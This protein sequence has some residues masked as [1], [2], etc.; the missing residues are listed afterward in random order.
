MT[1]D[2]KKLEARKADFV[3]RLHG[4]AK[5]SSKGG[6]VIPK[7]IRDALDIEPG[8]EVSFMLV[9]PTQN[10]KQDKRLSS[11]RI[12][13]VPRTTK[14]VLEI[15]AGMILRRPGE[16]LWTEDLVREHREEVEREERKIRREKAKRRKTASSSV[17]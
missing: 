4:K 16:P 1:R 3:P 5:V 6:V 10:M 2:R 9:P 17:R 15:T 8:D 11:I 14:E 13:K 7:D 12:T